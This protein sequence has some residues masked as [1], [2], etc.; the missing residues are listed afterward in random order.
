MAI[1]NTTVI[2]WDEPKVE[3]WLDITNSSW[4]IDTTDPKSNHVGGIVCGS[5]TVARLERGV[6]RTQMN[7]VVKDASSSKTAIEFDSANTRILQIWREG[8]RLNA[9]AFENREAY[10]ESLRKSG[11]GSGGGGGKLV[12]KDYPVEGELG[13]GEGARLYGEVGGG[14]RFELKKEAKGVGLAVPEVT[15]EKAEG[16]GTPL[17]I[18]G[19]FGSPV[20][21]LTVAELPAQNIE[22]PPD[23]VFKSGSAEIIDDTPLRKF[24]DGLVGTYG[25][26]GQIVLVYVHGRADSQAD[27]DVSNPKPGKFPGNLRLSKDRADAVAKKINSLL[28]G[29]N[30][31]VVIRFYGT[32]EDRLRVQEIEIPN[33][34]KKFPQTVTAPSGTIITLALSPK[35]EPE[36]GR[37]GQWYRLNESK[38]ILRKVGGYKQATHLLFYYD[39]RAYLEPLAENRSVGLSYNDVY[40]CDGVEK[41]RHEDYDGQILAGELSKTPDFTQERL[42][43]HNTP[44]AKE[45]L[46]GLD[47]Q[48]MPALVQGKSYYM[49]IPEDVI[50]K[51]HIGEGDDALAY[52][53][54]L[55]EIVKKAEADGGK[56]YVVH[57]N[58]ADK[59]AAKGIA[60]KLGLFV[61]AGFPSL[62]RNDVRF[63]FSSDWR[64][65][66]SITVSALSTSVPIDF[67]KPSIVTGT[68]LKFWLETLG[69]GLGEAVGEAAYPG[70]AACSA[71]Y[72][73]EQ[74]NIDFNKFVGE[75][76]GR[77]NPRLVKDA[78]T[79]IYKKSGGKIDDDEKRILKGE[80]AEILRELIIKKAIASSEY[81]PSSF[82]DSVNTYLAGEGRGFLL[83]GQTE[84]PIWMPEACSRHV[85]MS[86]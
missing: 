36:K 26:T 28:D 57:I 67:T 40:R 4:E 35:F 42:T 20:E 14:V 50:S 51:I 41:E 63:Y 76:A 43:T 34:A 79:V 7:I 45:V 65:P 54:A 46:K 56:Q 21:P 19:K 85:K 30:V 64:K 59:N 44:K 77:F 3:C 31:N 75:V 70:L 10:L 18:I 37:K 11:G 17:Q 72:G 49:P 8:G 22:L 60:E 84:V 38:G 78:L 81:T 12:I 68:Y 82:I 62:V 66:S 23:R 58:I 61:R 15:V 48:D 1:P 80:A 13:R 83:S 16:T 71:D 86:D 29:K 32:G 24:A 2:N 52:Q 39:G 25:A 69:K 74:L 9:R 47:V 33:R 5:E 55:R 73:D 53:V 27:A 6:D